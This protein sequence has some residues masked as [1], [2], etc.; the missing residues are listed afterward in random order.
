M[1]EGIITALCTPFKK[2][3]VDVD[4]Y[5]KIIGHQLEAKINGL[6]IGGTT[7]ES[8]TVTIEELKNLVGIAKAEVSKQAPVIVGTGTNSTATTIEKT[9]LAQ[10]WGADA[11]LIV[12]PYY[13]RPPQKGLIAHF[14]AIRDATKIPIILYNVPSRTGAGFEVDTI[15]KLSG[16]DRI[17][18]LK[19]ATG[20]LK[21]LEQ[22]KK[23]VPQ[24]FLLWSGDDGTAEEFCER[25]GHGA[26]SVLS[27]VIPNQ[28]VQMYSK[29]TSIKKFSQLNDLL[30]K[31]SN[32]IP[33]KTVLFLMKL[34]SSP[35]MRLPLVPASSE[36]TEQ[37]QAELQKL[38]LM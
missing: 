14:L 4:S 16:E 2:G 30:F 17:I 15:Q 5:K 34:I 6:V 24:N 12:V 25:G 20:D 7:G 37:L 38:E 8:P 27:H 35:E 26:I 32:P 13:N 21:F 23:S 28:M 11:A 33:L 31:E 29:K 22:I 10:S 1:N 3:Q 19:E 18:G 9:L 36:L